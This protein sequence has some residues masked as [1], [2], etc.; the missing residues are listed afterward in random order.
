MNPALLADLIVAL[1]LLIVAFV[2]LGL[3]LTFAGAFL[4][5]EWVRNRWFRC[6][7][8]AVIVFVAAQ[9]AGFGQLCPLTIWE[10]ELRERAGQEGRAGSFIGRICHD[11]L[12]VDVDQA[13]LDWSYVAFA[14]LVLAALYFVEPRWRRQ[15]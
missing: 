13:L 14:L 10:H 4:H 5:W 2:I 15:G 9:G 8:L 1:H 11:L 6:A 3:L 7:H 12:F